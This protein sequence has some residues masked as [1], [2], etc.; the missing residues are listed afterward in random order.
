ME[1]QVVVS[2]KTILITLGVLLALYVTYQLR[3]ILSILFIALI[4]VISLEG[5]IEYLQKLNFMNKP[6]PRVLAVLLTYTTFL[7]VLVLVFTTAVPLIV[8]QA[9]KL[10]S[11]FSYF[12]VNLKVDEQSLFESL[13]FLDVLSQVTN[14]ESISSVVISSVS[15][16]SS[17]LTLIVIAIYMS[18]DWLNIKTR[19]LGIFRKKA[20]KDAEEV[21]ESVEDD[22]GS[23]VKGQVLLMLVVGIFNLVG[24]MAAGINYPFALGFIAGVLEIVPVIGPFFSAVVS[25]AVG[26]SQSSTKG[27]M[28][29]GVAVLVQQLENNFLVPKIMEKVSGFSPLVILLALLVGNEFFGIVGAILAVPMTM[30][31][32][33]IVRKFVHYPTKS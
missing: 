9:Q 4:L 20:R 24:Y 29:L 5:A 17:F 28:A 23:W 18:L 13:N 6:L 10:V 2:V 19:F 31:L 30:I 15:A 3:G 33:I 12:L 11:N 32:A 1:K 25:T 26:F 7:F 22:V 27:F 14:K 8:S 16:V 21:L